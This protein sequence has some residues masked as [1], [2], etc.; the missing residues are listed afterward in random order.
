MSFNHRFIEASDV[1]TAWISGMQMLSESPGFEAFNL[2]VRIKNPIVEND[3]QRII[4]N[5]Y[6]CKHH[7][8]W[9]DDH[10]N[11]VVETIFPNSYLYSTCQDPKIPENRQAFYDKYRK[12]SG[13]IRI[14]N[15]QGTYFQR[16]TQ[17]PDWDT[18]KNRQI[19]QLENI[20]SKLNSGKAT[21]VV[22]EMGLDGDLYDSVLD[23]RLY[24][25]Q[26]DRKKT[27]GFPC[28]SHISI[29]PE[30]SKTP[31]GKIHMA[32]LYRNHY[33]T[34]KAYGNYLGLGLLLKFIADA[35]GREVGELVCVS[36]LAGIDGLN[37]TQ[38]DGLLTLLRDG[39][40]R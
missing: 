10:I 34:E 12:N 38:V 31:T 32:A 36:S 28:L 6:L 33:F 17:W 2:V 11:T 19:N 5:D 23:A 25:P 13:T 7:R 24:D 9:E 18:P 40:S 3:S 35:T 22:Y 16:L 26:Q 4:I 20:I 8:K 37:K 29:K 27:L 30:N 39:G 21:R 1:T 14:F 15:L